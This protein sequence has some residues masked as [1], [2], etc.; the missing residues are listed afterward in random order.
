MSRKEP[1]NRRRLLSDL[2]ARAPSWPEF[3]ARCRAKGIQLSEDTLKRARDEGRATLRTLHAVAEALGTRVEDYIGEEAGAPR[4]YDLSGEWLAVYLETWPPLYEVS[5][6]KER[7]SI[8]QNG[9]WLKGTYEFIA[10][11]DPSLKRYTV[12]EMLGRYVADFVTGFY[13]VRGREAAQ[14]IGS[15][16]LKLIDR[17]TYGEGF[18][19]FCSDT[20]L[21]SVSPNIW[22]KRRE[23]HSTTYEKY[24]MKS[25]IEQQQFFTRPIPR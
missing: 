23:E 22:V 20:G 8:I 12:F 16:Q 13:F 17:A 5:R 15:F 11:D 19:T 10:N 6:T 2:A 7:L 1:F 14:G 18:C 24:A 4:R 21:V 3:E 9:S 25:I